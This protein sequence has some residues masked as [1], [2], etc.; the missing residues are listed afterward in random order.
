MPSSKQA[1][2]SLTSIS[3][4]VDASTSPVQVG[5]PNGRG[6]ESIAQ[7]EE[8]ALEGLFSITEKVLKENQNTIS[9][10]QSFI[11]NELIWA[12]FN[13]TV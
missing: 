8:Q 7:T 11:S 12:L 13:T 4:V 2:T 3:L 5:I 10:H 9:D 6:W 1:K